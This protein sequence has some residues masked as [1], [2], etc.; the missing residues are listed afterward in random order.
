MSVHW[1]VWVARVGALGALFCGIVGLIVGFD[2]DTWKLGVSGWFTGG[3]LAAL[4][5]IIVYLDDAA[6]SRHK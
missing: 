6:E 3:S 2:G 1:K 5:S 4:V